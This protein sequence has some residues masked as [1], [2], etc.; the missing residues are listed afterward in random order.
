RRRRMPARLAAPTTLGRCALGVIA[1]PA[2]YL[3]R[4]PSLRNAGER[5]GD[6]EG[7]HAVLALVALDEAPEGL[8]FSAAERGADPVVEAGHTPLVH[9]FEGRQFHGLEGLPR[10]PFHHPQHPALARRDEQ[11]GLAAAP[12]TS[13][14][15]DAMHVRFGVVRNVVIEDVA[16]PLDI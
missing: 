9:L 10:G 6:V 16:P 3:Q 15:P 14:A 13:G 4:R 5:R 8:G 1:I 7:G 12:G 11:D 2:G